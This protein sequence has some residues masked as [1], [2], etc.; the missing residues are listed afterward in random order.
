MKY[1]DRKIVGILASNVEPATALNVIGH[2]AVAIGKYSDAE[3]M[4]REKL[5]DKSGIAHTGISQFPV[6]ITKVKAGKLKTAIEKA[7]TC[8]E[9]LVV[10]YPR[11]MLDTRT[12]DDLAAAIANKE[13]QQIEYLG[14]M[15][16]GDAKQID[17]ITGK[18]QLWRID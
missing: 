15:F 3:I 8:P 1:E 10:D 16:Y 4:G 17:E 6:I 13:N 14:A 7:K 12:D 5:I 9:L 11:E 2:L 18:F